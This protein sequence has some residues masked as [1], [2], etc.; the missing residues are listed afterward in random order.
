MTDVVIT[1]VGV[2]SPYGVGWEAFQRGILSCEPRV[3]PI[4]SFDA[5]TFPTTVAAEVP[6]KTLDEQWLRPLVPD[7]DHGQELIHAWDRSGLLRDRRVGMALAAASEAWAHSGCDDDERG[8]ALCLA[9]GL[10]R[11]L[12]GDLYQILDDGRLDWAG[13]AGRGL[14]AH[15][16]RIAVDHPARAVRELLGLTGR[17]LVNA[18]AC[19]AGSMSL[20]HAARLIRRGAADV[21]IAGGADS[22]IN[23]LGVGGMSRLGAP[24]PRASIDACRPFHRGRDGL[25]MGEGA[26]VFVVERGDRAAARGAQP[27][28]RVLGGATTQDAHAVTAPWPDGRCAARSMQAALIDADLCAEQVGYVNAHGTGTPLN[29][30]AET[31]AIRTVF[32]PHTSSLPVSS[33]KGAIGHWMAAS[34]AAEA[35]AVVA[36]FAGGRLPPTAFLD[37]VDPACELDHVAIDPRDADVEI[38]LSN[39]FG[40]GGQNAT[41]VLGAPV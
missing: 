27:L 7:D 30:P 6:H 23:P 31:L 33:V 40:F 35:A 32:G 39:S 15:R 12:L 11:A 20:H 24:S 18:S 10:E 37:D 4:R 34:G 17:T 13:A 2:V 16:L 9:L 29:D 19:A 28:A 41:L 8:A 1:G 38:A 14:P 21:V 22:M 5:S 3:G 36:A 26:A 25:A